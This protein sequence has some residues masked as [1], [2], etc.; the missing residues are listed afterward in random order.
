MPSQTP[1]MPQT[2]SALSPEEFRAL[3]EA[4]SGKR[5]QLTLKQNRSTML[6]VRWDSRNCNQ[7]NIS[8]HPMFLRAPRNVMD[9]LVCYIREENQTFAPEIKQFI[10]IESHSI[11]PSE[12][13]KM[14]A[15]HP[16]EITL[17]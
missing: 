14:G 13:A 10:S 12:Q 8:V 11:P 1:F 9:A 7:A 4:Q 2:A 17:I 15:L 6:S 16:K 3:L 5:V